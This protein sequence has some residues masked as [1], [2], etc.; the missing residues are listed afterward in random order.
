MADSTLRIIQAALAV[1]RRKQCGPECRGCLPPGKD[2]TVAPKPPAWANPKRPAGWPFV[3]LPPV[4]GELS[5]FHWPDRL[6][7]VHPQGWW[8]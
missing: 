3:P 2:Y 5:T 6:P 7:T 8:L 4:R 1:W